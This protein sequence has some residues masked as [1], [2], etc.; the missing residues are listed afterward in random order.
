MNSKTKKYICHIVCFP[1]IRVLYLC[2]KHLVLKNELLQKTKIRIIVIVLHQKN[3]I[4]GHLKYGIQT[5]AVK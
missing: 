5:Q 2:I 3:K 1:N 4:Y